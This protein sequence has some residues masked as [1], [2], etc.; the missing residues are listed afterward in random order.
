MVIELIPVAFSRGGRE[1]DEYIIIIINDL[2]T[3]RPFINE[4]EEVK[5]FQK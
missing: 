2:R 1:K 4:G 5:E 3:I